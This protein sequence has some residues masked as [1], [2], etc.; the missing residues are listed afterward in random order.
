MEHTIR[1][2]LLD[3]VPDEGEV[4]KLMLERA[5]CEVVLLCD[6]REGLAF[7]KEKGHLLNLVVATEMLPQVSGKDIL[8]MAYVVNSS[9][10]TI[11]IT[12]SPSSDIVSGL[13][14]RFDYV[15][16]KGEPIG[17][18]QVQEAVSIAF[19]S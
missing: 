17:L 6:G 12:S 8:E 3:G 2:L 16:H 10:R 11:A 15:L 19:I 13:R 4:L 7:L 1:T 9:V 5:G 18:R 14:E